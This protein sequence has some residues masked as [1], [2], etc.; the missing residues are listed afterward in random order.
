MGRNRH[1][2]VEDYVCASHHPHGV[3]EVAWR[4]LEHLVAKCPTCE[5]AWVRLGHLREVYL[6]QLRSLRPARRRDVPVDELDGTPDGIARSV[7]SLQ[8]LRYARR[9]I[10]DEKC[11]LV[12]RTAPSKRVSKVRRAYRRFHSLLM[13]EMLIEECRRRVRNDPVDAGRLAELV[14]HVLAWTKDRPGLPQAAVLLARAEAHRA[15]AL[16]IAGD[17]PGAERVFIALR[18]TLAERPLGDARAAAE[19]AS[20]EASL[21]IGQRRFP[22]AE[23]HLERAILA[24]RHAGDGELL[25]RI[26]IQTANLLRASGR[27]ER[28][29]VLLEA[30]AAQLGPGDDPFLLLCTV[31]G[32]VN[33]LC[34]L[35]RAAEA[36]RLLVS[37]LDLYEE[38]RE[39][40]AGA[41]YR[42]LE[43]RCALALGDLATA[44]AAFSSSRDAHLTL[45]RG[46]DAALDAL[47]LAETLF[48][49]G[50][51]RELERL[52]AGLVAFFR[53]RGVEGEALAA[54]QLLARTV[55]TEAVTA[56][57]FADLR[58]RFTAATL[59][60]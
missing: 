14:P 23:E 45:G 15:N 55:A 38:S 56:G 3:A 32:R 59:G 22:E 25:A 58:R 54:L 31:T 9:R 46:Y 5:D 7:A 60:G 11:E 1:L 57:L 28:V 34:D 12:F 24:A 8:K 43:G 27:P 36:R 40:L 16:R 18:G 30:A 29:P 47:C 26:H 6:D 20:L 48:R 4:C 2:R 37:H 13:A 50:K 42:C 52:A 19:L 44:Q 21:C 49:A 10:V 39:P 41:N 53:S 51:G 35:G 17:L 33:A